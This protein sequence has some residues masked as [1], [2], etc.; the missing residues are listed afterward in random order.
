MA[1]DENTRY[2]IEKQFALTENNAGNFFIVRSKEE[3]RYKLGLLETKLSY[4]Q[5]R[6][7]KEVDPDSIKRCEDIINNLNMS[8]L[9]LR[10]NINGK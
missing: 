10:K 4:V 8:I 2:Y 9:S 6:L 1:T 3:K 5:E 7:K